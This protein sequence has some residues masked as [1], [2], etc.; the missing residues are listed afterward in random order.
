[1]GSDRGGSWAILGDMGVRADSKTSFLVHD[2]GVGSSFSAVRSTI[3]RHLSSACHCHC[4]TTQQ[5]GGLSLGVLRPAWRCTCAVLAI[6]MDKRSTARYSAQKYPTCAR[7]HKPFKFNP[8]CSG[9]LQG[10][11]AVN[12]VYRLLLLASR[13][14]QAAVAFARSLLVV[15][16]VANEPAPAPPNPC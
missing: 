8:P 10:F 2:A 9:K 3:F 15:G 4:C 6:A 11:R 5:H 1:M 13:L 14:D 7:H 12:C 16:A